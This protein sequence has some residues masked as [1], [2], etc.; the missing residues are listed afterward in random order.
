MSCHSL[1]GETPSAKLADLIGGDEAK[2]L[3]VVNHMPSF[4]ASRIG[5]LLREA[6]ERF[7]MDGFSFIQIDRE[8]PW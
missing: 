6:T 7:D 5:E 3:A 4:V 8:L 1:R 2:Q